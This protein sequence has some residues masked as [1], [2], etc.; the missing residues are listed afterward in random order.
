MG[1]SSPQVV[2]VGVFQQAASGSY[3]NT[4]RTLV[5]QVGS[6]CQT[7]SRTAQGDATNAGEH[8]HDNAAT[9]V[10]YQGETV[11]WTEFG[12]EHSQAAIEAT[13]AAGAGGVTK[14]VN[15]TTYYQDHPG[16]FLR[17]VKVE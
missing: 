15:S 14:S 11:T 7:W 17:I 3:V 8:L 5:Y 6:Q 13:C 12:P 16:V 2:T 10:S 9:N 4:S 1:T